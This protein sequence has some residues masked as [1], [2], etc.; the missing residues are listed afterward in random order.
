MFDNNMERAQCELE[1]KL[2]QTQYVKGDRD[3]F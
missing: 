3:S 1:S 2:D